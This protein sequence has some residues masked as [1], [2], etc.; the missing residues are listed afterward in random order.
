MR[1]KTVIF[2]W[3]PPPLGCEKMALRRLNPAILLLYFP[4]LVALTEFY[5]WAVSNRGLSYNGPGGFESPAYIDI[6]LFILSSMVTFRIAMYLA[7]WANKKTETRRARVLA[8][9]CTFFVVLM[10]GVYG[11]LRRE[12]PGVIVYAWDTIV[13][14]CTPTGERIG[15]F[16]I[17]ACG[18]AIIGMVV[19]LLKH[20]LKAATT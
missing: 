4:V 20:L 7:E 8:Y 9:S 2:L 14:C 11:Y 10:F 1:L 19:Y 12:Y 13:N 6:P 3:H 15:L 18:A 17:F 16:V 5:T